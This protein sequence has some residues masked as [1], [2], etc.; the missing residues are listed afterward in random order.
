MNSSA[1]G[2]TTRSTE[3]SAK[4]QPVR[5]GEQVRG[6]VVVDASSATGCGSARGSRRRAARPAA[7]RSRRCRRPSGR[8]RPARGRAGSAR[9]ASRTSR[10]AS[11]TAS[12]AVAKIRPCR[13]LSRSPHSADN[14]IWVLREGARAVVVDPGRRRARAGLPRRAKGSTLAA[15]LVTHHHGD[16]VGGVAALV[17]ARRGVPV[18]GPAREAIPGRTRALARRRRGRRCRSSPP[19]LRVHRRPRPHGRP[20]RVRRRRRAAGRCSSAA[21]RCSPAAAGGCSRARRRRCAASLAQLAALPGDDARLLRA[22]VHA[23]EPALRARGRAR[24][25]RAGGAHRARAGEARARRARR[26]RRRSADERATNPFLRAARAGGAG[27]RGAPCGAPAGRRRSRRSPRC[28]RGRTRSS[29]YRVAGGAVSTGCVRRVAR[30]TLPRSRRLPSPHRR[31]RRGRSTIG[32]RIALRSPVFAALALVVLAA[33]AT[34]PAPKPDPAV[35]PVAGRRP[36]SSPSASEPPPAPHAI[37]AAPIDKLLV[38]VFP[39][40]VAAPIS[41]RC[42][43]PSTTCGTASCAATRCPT[44]RGRWSRSGSSGT[45]TRPDYVARMVDRSRRYLYHIVTEVDQREH[46]ARDRA[47]ADDR[48]RVQPARAVDRARRRHLAVHSVDRQALRPRAELLGR[49]APRRARGDRQGARLPD[50]A[51]SATSTT[52]S[53]RSPP[54]T[55]ARAT[56]AR[57]LARN[58]ERGPAARPT[59]RSRCRT[60]RATT[61]PSCRR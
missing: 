37:V 16:H 23:R 48:E 41:S 36:S 35:T 11:L 51:A 15:I 24:Q 30:L 25:R 50:E 47:A 2:I 1:C 54:T 27:R 28:A 20:H 6:R 56:S 44:S 22:R 61:C 9:A 7:R 38:P 17:D 4:R 32:S 33:C 12:P 8:S 60:R 3:F 14:Y 45:P 42:R 29:A 5:I 46:A 49:L 13:R 21:T 53:S 43:R 52:G 58:R 59:R 31:A 39:A 19:R 55:G 18:F 57:A 40:A 34:S 10:R 26:C